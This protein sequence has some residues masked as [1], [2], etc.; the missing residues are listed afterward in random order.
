MNRAGPDARQQGERERRGKAVDKRDA[1]ERHG[2]DDVRHDHAAPPRPAIGGR[3][4]HGPEQHGRD[5]V[6]EEDEADRPRRV[7][8]V[9]RDDEERDVAGAVAECRLGEDRVVDARHAL[10]SQEIECARAIR[11]GRVEKSR[12]RTVARPAA[13]PVKILTAENHPVPS[14]VSRAAL[15]EFQAENLRIRGDYLTFSPVCHGFS[16]TNLCKRRLTA[17]V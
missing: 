3:A 17:G 10:A 11:S 8:P 16:C 12:G 6:S 1:E 15:H 13:Q 2:A 9:V 4:E 5:E 7:E 14:P